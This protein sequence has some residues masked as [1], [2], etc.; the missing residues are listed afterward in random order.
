MTGATT[1]AT[2]SALGM[3]LSRT[4][5]PVTVLGPGRRAG[6]WFQGCTIRCSGCL[7]IDT[8]A[9][10]TSATVPVSSVLDWLASLPAD[11]VDG[12]T[13]SGG[14]PT[15]QAGALT[16]V[17][18]GI[19]S[20]RSDRPVDVLMFTGREPEWV[21][22]QIRRGAAEQLWP[23]LDA[24]M[25]G[26]YIGAQAGTSVLRGSENQ[27]LIL[28]TPLGTARYAHLDDS[29]RRSVQ[30]QMT[31]DGLWLVGI[32]LPGDLEAIESG[33]S[34]AGFGLRQTSWRRS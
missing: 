24:V 21:E 31:E 25:A 13:I 19:E 4:H 30:L 34:A 15:E 9:G 5:Y 20:W 14:E 27:R 3:R 8:W 2:A 32:P 10:S 23:G 26:P 16:A 12:V 18:R 6:I 11:D 7:A 22:E 1:P 17:L 28:R 29:S 33:L